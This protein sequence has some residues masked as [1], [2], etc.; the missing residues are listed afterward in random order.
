MG[1]LDAW[2]YFQSADVVVNTEWVAAWKARTGDER[3]TNK[4]MEGHYIGFNMWVNAVEVAGSSEVDAVRAKMYC[5]TFPNL[6]G[7]VAEMLPKDH[8]SKPV[9]IG[10]IQADGQFDIISQTNEVPGGAWTNHLPE[11]A[12][13]VFDWPSL[14]CRMYNTQTKSCV[15]IGSNY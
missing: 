12:I 14:E 8:L 13:L 9:L 10:E 2:N 6:T 3:V 7:G 15:Q 5:Q 4:T 1:H 11:F